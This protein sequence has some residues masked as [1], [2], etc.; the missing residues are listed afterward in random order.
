MFYLFL[1]AVIAECGYNSPTSL[2]GNTV[3]YVKTVKSNLDGT[4]K[5]IHHAAIMTQAPDNNTYIY[6]T[7]I[8]QENRNKFVKAMMKE[9]AD[10][11]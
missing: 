4:L 6:N 7:M 9:I 11:E 8:Q 3:L 2:V 10:H 5:Y 1:A